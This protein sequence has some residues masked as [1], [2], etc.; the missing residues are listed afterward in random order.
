MVTGF[1]IFSRSSEK[2]IEQQWQTRFKLNCVP[3][4]FM[5]KE[6]N[7]LALLNIE[8]IE[9]CRKTHINVDDIHTKLCT[10]IINEMNNT[11]SENRNQVRKKAFQ[12]QKTLLEWPSERPNGKNV[13]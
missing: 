12:T 11:F 13:H 9:A 8:E 2:K 10:S 5:N 6:T 7:R 3:V 1:S 4:D